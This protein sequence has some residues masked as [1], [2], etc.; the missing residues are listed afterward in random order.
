MGSACYGRLLHTKH[1]KVIYKK[2][3]TFD[4]LDDKDNKEDSKIVDTTSVDKPSGDNEF[5][6]EMDSDIEGDIPG[7]LRKIGIDS[8]YLEDIIIIQQ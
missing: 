7:N 3:D 8:E 2:Y 4:C 5:D 6:S 1:Y